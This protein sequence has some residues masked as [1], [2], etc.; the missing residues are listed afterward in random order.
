MEPHPCHCMHPDYEDNA[1]ADMAD[2]GVADASSQCGFVCAWNLCPLYEAGTR[3]VLPGTCS[4]GIFD[5]TV[6][7]PE[8]Y[9]I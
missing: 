7:C 9:P 8:T 5:F 4:D 2:N 1:C 3:N 6:T